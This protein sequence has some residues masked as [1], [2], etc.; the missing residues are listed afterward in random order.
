M[1]TLSTHKLDQ[2]TAIGWLAATAL[3]LAAMGCAGNYG[4]VA[5]SREVTATFQAYE[6]LAD[7]NYYYSGPDAEPFA[8]IGIHKNYTLA[9]DFWKPVALTPD[10]LRGWL[11]FPRFRVGN[12]LNIY[13]ARLVGPAGEAIGVWYAVRDWRVMGTVRLEADNRV[14]VTT[15][16]LHRNRTH[17]TVFGNSF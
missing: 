5:P 9:S 7:H 3:L 1:K 12:D 10:R 11:N 13:G 16:D 6:V 14:V 4:K 15:P 17:L 8:V 2:R